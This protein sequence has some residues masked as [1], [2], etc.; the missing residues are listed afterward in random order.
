MGHVAIA[1]T[2]TTVDDDG[3]DDSGRNGEV[4]EEEEYNIVVD[5]VCSRYCNSNGGGGQWH[6]MQTMHRAVLNATRKE[7]EERPKE[8]C[9]TPS[10]TTPN[11]TPNG[12]AIEMPGWLVL[13]K[14]AQEQEKKTREKE[15]WVKSV[16]RAFETYQGD[17]TA[18]HQAKNDEKEGTEVVSSLFQCLS[19]TNV[20]KILEFML[21]PGKWSLMGRAHAC[22]RAISWMHHHSFAWLLLSDSFCTHF[23]LVLHLFIFRFK[24]CSCW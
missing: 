21:F 13:S 5:F 14:E 16:Q 17:R 23:A 12:I 20:L 3:D 18:M 1:K 10:P 2:M 24:C 19:V 6:T 4:E 7:Q 8:E 9:Y 15:K 11:D 22:M